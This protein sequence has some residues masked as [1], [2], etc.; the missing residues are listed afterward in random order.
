MRPE[1]RS[2]RVELFEERFQTEAEAEAFARLQKRRGGSLRVFTNDSEPT[3]QLC[4]WDGNE[5]RNSGS[6]DL[7]PDSV[8]FSYCAIPLCKMDLTQIQQKKLQQKGKMANFSAVGYGGHMPARTDEECWG[9]FGVLGSFLRAPRFKTWSEGSLYL[10]HIYSGQ[11]RRDHKSILHV[12]GKP[13]SQVVWL[14]GKEWYS[15]SNGL[16]PS[17]T[18]SNFRVLQV[19]ERRVEGK[20]IRFERPRAY[21]FTLPSILG[22]YSFEFRTL[23]EAE[24]YRSYLGGLDNC[25][26][27]G[28]T[29]EPTFLLTW[30]DEKGNERSSLEGD[31]PYPGAVVSLLCIRDSSEKEVKSYQVGVNLR[32]KTREEAELYRKWWAIKVITESPKDPTILMTWEKDGV[33]YGSGEGLLPDPGAPKTRIEFISNTKDIVLTAEEAPSPSGSTSSASTPSAST[34]SEGVRSYQCLGI[35]M[36]PRFKTRSEASIYLTNFYPGVDGICIVPVDLEPSTQMV[37]V[38]REGE[39]EEWY[40][41]LNGLTPY[42]AAS[43]FRFLPMGER[44]VE[45][46]EIR[47]ERPSPHVRS[48][49]V[50]YARFSTLTEAET[51]LKW[52]GSSV[53]IMRDQLRNPTHTLVWQELDGVSRFS[54]GKSKWYCGADG[55]TP[56]SKAVNFQVLTW[57]ECMSSPRDIH[58]DRNPPTPVKSYLVELGGK[59]YRFRTREEAE[60]YRECFTSSGMFCRGG[61]RSGKTFALAVLAVYERERALSA[62]IVGHPEEADTQ[63]VWYEGSNLFGSKEGLLPPEWGAHD[64]TARPLDYLTDTILLKRAEETR[65][66]CYEQYSEGE[67]IDPSLVNDAQ[68]LPVEESSSAGW[69]GAFGVLALLGAM[70]GRERSTSLNQASNQEEGVLVEEAAVEDPSRVERRDQS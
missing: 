5:T 66:E 64:L 35:Y 15:G 48:F 18:A 68:T 38:E 9:I 11:T 16:T 6:G 12:K 17:E 19:E 33:R 32:F 67:S 27:T 51:Y 55:L 69:L 65:D 70:G 2:Y 58:F 26:V 28:I 22:G 21:Q 40:S 30:V 39:E 59:K 49:V 44:R 62:T 8:G 23:L 46:K 63:L 42:E 1:T 57:K 50:G 25:E 34:P 45:G 41:G 31:L 3:H 14:E 60:A 54:P 7:P 36:A 29:G 47:F 52:Q 10:K 13:V 56:S 20:E 24:W 4:W 43:N 37:W 61:Q 53:P